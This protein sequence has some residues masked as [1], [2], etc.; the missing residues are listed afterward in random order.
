VKVRE[1]FESEKITKEQVDD[2]REESDYWESCGAF[3]IDNWDRAIE[4]MTPKQAKWLDKIHE[5]L[6][7]RRIDGKL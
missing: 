7:E 2:A 1:L 5:D 6:V 4:S 3:V